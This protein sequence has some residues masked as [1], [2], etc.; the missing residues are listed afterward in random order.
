M[1]W[2][3]VLSGLF[4]ATK[5]VK[6]ITS[7]ASSAA[8]GIDALF[9]TDEEKAELSK[10]VMKIW[11]DVQKVTANESSIRSVARRIIAIGVVATYLGIL[12]CGCAVYKLDPEYSRFLFEVAVSLNTF[13]LTI[14]V[15]YFGYYALSNIIKAKKDK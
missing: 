5:A 9:F 12:L 6:P 7:I 11:L 8:K 3:S 1:A 14:M 10:A 15:F 13:V 2:Y 4:G